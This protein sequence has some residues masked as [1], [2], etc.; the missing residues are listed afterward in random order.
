MRFIIGAFHWQHHHPQN[1][2]ITKPSE[3]NIV[4]HSARIQ[5]LCM[6]SWFY[7]DSS[8]MKKGFQLLE[9]LCQ[10]LCKQTFHE[11]VVLSADWHSWYTCTTQCICM[12]LQLP[13]LDF[14]VHGWPVP[15]CIW[16]LK[17]PIAAGDTVFSQAATQSS[18]Q[19]EDRAKV[20][21]AKVPATLRQRTETRG[22]SLQ[23]HE[24]VSVPPSSSSMGQR[25]PF[26]S[27]PH[28]IWERKVRE[29]SC[30]GCW[31]IALIYEAVAVSSLHIE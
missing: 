31:V 3:E 28:F 11:A 25:N 21:E 23:Q 2:L 22:T 18:C 12:T 27:L 5:L 14:A 20:T 24:Q 8:R 7:L 15:K 30:A 1:Y 6:S 26:F 10:P 9:P 16:H 17:M 29:G 4:I 19:E 13:L